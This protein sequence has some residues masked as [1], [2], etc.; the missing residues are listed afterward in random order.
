MSKV[1]WDA[2]NVIILVLWNFGKQSIEN[3]TFRHSK[4]ENNNYRGFTGEKAKF[5]DFSPMI[6]HEY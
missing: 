3:I 6:Y 1:F 2:D 5:S 4:L